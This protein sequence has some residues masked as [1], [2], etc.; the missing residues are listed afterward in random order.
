MTKRQ[1]REL[2]FKTLFMIDFYGSREE[3]VSQ[4]ELFLDNEESVDDSAP[5]RDRIQG[6]L[7]ALPG[8][9]DTINELALGWKTSR[10]AKVD[11]TLLRMAIYEMRFESLNKGIA[12]NEAVE[13][14]KLYGEERSY[15]FVNGILSKVD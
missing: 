6:F 12:I 13:L 10:I 14:A 4:A 8:I 7:D 15:A 5:F 11:L 9:D 2:F 1:E 3:I